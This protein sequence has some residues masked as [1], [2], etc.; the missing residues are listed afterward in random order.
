MIARATASMLLLAAILCVASV[1]RAH[2]V[3]PA[4]LELIEREGGQVDVTWKV[5]LYEGKPLPLTPILPDGFRRSSSIDRA[6]IGN[7]IVERWTLVADGGELAGA[8]IRVDGLSAIATDALVRVE[9]ADGR[10]HREVLRK[11]TP[12]TIVLS[13]TGTDDG[14]RLGAL[15]AV[16]RARLPILLVGALALGLIASSR[17]RGIL[18]CAVALIAGS[19]VGYT[20]P[21]AL[22]AEWF[23]SRSLPS[24]EEATQVLHGLL[25]NTYRAFSYENEEAAYD[26]L[27]L[28]VVGDLL[29]KVYL[30]NRDAMQMEEAE[31]AT[32]IIDR[33][34]VKSIE[35]MERREDG[36]ITMVASWD[37]Y[38]SVR[39]WGHVHYRL[40]AYRAELILVPT[41]NYWKLAGV[42]L[43]EEERVL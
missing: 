4:F 36:G 43:L 1:A 33:L 42:E 23:A 39:H 13:G 10:T 14:D 21:L 8:E 2:N 17:R 31:G 11:N 9:L 6:I 26:R 3:H 15:R 24:E 16:D 22:G 40:N 29:S 20:A 19:I 28:G 5:P 18:I 41:G 37:V 38:G 12:S 25:L 32:T 27:A 30:E 34:D 35:S 7:A